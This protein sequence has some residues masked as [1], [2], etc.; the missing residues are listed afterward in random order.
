M[1]KTQT[2]SRHHY[3]NSNA[4]QSIC[5]SSKH[6]E[7]GKSLKFIFPV[8]GVGEVCFTGLALWKSSEAQWSACGGKTL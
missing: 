3:F 4:D 7:A 5:A 1:Q 6:K 8:E 2:R